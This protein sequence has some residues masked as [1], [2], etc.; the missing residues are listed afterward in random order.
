MVKL[1]F[2]KTLTISKNG[3]VSVNDP[4]DEKRKAGEG[5]FCQK[6]TKSEFRAS[7]WGSPRRRKKKKP[8][9]LIILNCR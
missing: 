6:K 8:A 1:A 7:H 4:V 3:H 9:F 5:R 2:F